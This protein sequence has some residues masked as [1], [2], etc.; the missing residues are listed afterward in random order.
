M[1]E[2]LIELQE[3]ALQKVA[4]ASELK[5]LNEVRVS[6]LGKKGPITEVLRGMGKLSAEERPKIGALA[7]DV[8]EA[9]AS[10]IEEKQK[11]LETAA[12]N[13]KL[14]TETIDVTLPG[15]PVNKGNLHPLTR[16]VEE[17]EDLFIGMG[18]T[19]A[20]GPEVE[21]DYYNFEAL[22]LPKSHPARDMQDSFYITDE[23]LMRTH[24]SP[25]QAR[26]MEK[27]KGQGPVKIICPGKVYRRDNDDATH[28]H[29]FQQIEGL[30]ID[31]NISMSDLKGTLDVFA[32]KV[33]GQDR[34]IRLRPS[35]FPFTEPSVEVDIS[36]KIC[37][38]KGCSV[39][40]QTGWIEVLGGGIVHP[41]VLEMAGFDSK[42]YSGFAFG[43]GVERI[44]MLKYGVDDIRHFYTN[45][46]RFL[47]QFH[48]HEA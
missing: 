42:K 21:S 18:Y 34:E 35:F 3:E 39:C 8:R 43:I 31:E 1:Q 40:K 19:V 20:E 30:V 25:V 38:G 14:A 6:Y 29:Q 4:A 16:V 36:C 48:H 22:N 27:H 11:A 7:N 46:V 47:K 45:D 12:V 10:K 9:I 44:A 23:I 17:I 32:K 5:E 26:T 37:G 13:A 2:R 28:S 33:F 15:R 41:N 24:T